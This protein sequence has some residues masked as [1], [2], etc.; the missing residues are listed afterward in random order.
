MELKV[1]FSMD[2]KTI[3]CIDR[4]AGALAGIKNL[5]DVNVPLVTQEKTESTP[6]DRPTTEMDRLH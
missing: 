2:K 4:L 5:D 6:Q 3:D 1:T